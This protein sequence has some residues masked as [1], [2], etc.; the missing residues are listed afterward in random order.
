MVELRPA[1]FIEVGDGA[2]QC[3]QQKLAPARVIR[4]QHVQRLLVHQLPQGRL[5]LRRQ[6]R[7]VLIRNLQG[8]RDHFPHR[9]LHVG[10][11]AAYESIGDRVD[12][13]PSLPTLELLLEFRPPRMIA[14]TAVIDQLHQEIAPARQENRAVVELDLQHVRGGGGAFDRRE[15]VADL[16]RPGAQVVFGAE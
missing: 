14:H 6:N 16:A 13:G 3:G 8:A 7:A 15:V 12:R 2:V 11:V 1:G 5:E 10:V 9:L 4:R